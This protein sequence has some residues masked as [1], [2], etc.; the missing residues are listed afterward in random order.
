MK[1]KTWLKSAMAA[2]VAGTLAFSAAYAADEAADFPKRPITL[3]V[4][5]SPGGAV[6]ILARLLSEKL[7]DKLGQTVVV[8]YKPGAGTVVGTDFVARS[9]PDGHTVGMVVTSHV[10]NPSLRP[11]LPYDTEKDLAGVGQLAASEIVIT[12]SPELG[13]KALPEIIEAAKKDPQLLTYASP[14]SGSSMHLAGELLKGMAGIDMMHVPFKGSG[15]AY[16]EVMSGRVSM[17]IDPLFSS[18]PHIQSGR[19]VPVAV[20]GPERNQAVPDVP[21][22]AETLPGFQVQSV[23]GVVVPRAT[24]RP[25][26]NKLSQAFAD[27]LA[28][29]EIEKRLGEI[30]MQ[31]VGSSPEAFDAFINTE[32]KKWSEVVA[33]SG[34]AN[35]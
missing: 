28:M 24:P 22:V 12:A 1:T 20:T 10:I 21:S 26:V 13:M 18:L 7:Q 32:I 4:P 8:I 25:V 29:P 2:C 11:D 19:L 34:A 14:G 23:F 27:V 5:N 16:P 31:P 3:V 30:G 6:D 15:P 9:D 17:L 35:D 33:R